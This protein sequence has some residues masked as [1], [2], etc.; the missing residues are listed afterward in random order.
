MVIVVIINFKRGTVG[1]QAI[2]SSGTRFSNDGIA[3]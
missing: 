1:T 3:T 2:K